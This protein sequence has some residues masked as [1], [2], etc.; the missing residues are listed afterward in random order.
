MSALVDGNGETLFRVQR[1]GASLF[2][3]H[4]S[5][6]RI[7]RCPS[8]GRAKAVEVLAWKVH[9]MLPHLEVDALLAYVDN[10]CDADAAVGP[11]P[12]T[13]REHLT[14]SSGWV[15]AA[16]EMAAV[17]REEDRSAST[18]AWSLA[19]RRLLWGLL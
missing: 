5:N 14:W 18:W 3:G 17:E 6:G 7:V 4:P 13:R 19:V 8:A 11:E 1:K 2:V 16:R 12:Q 10:A 9:R 15:V